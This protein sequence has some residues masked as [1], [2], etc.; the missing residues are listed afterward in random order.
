M[1][2]LIYFQTEILFIIIFTVKN[3]FK[4]IFKLFIFK[5]MEFFELKLS[6]SKI[7]F[8]YLDIQVQWT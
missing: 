8:N 7:F 5:L 2:G 1:F 6:I 4:K 3:N